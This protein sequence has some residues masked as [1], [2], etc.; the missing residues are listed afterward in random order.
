MKVVRR[1]LNCQS[2]FEANRF[3]PHDQEYCGRAECR[4]A[5]ACAA[6]KKWRT[7]QCEKDADFRRKEST[8]LRLYRQAQRRRAAALCGLDPRSMLS[9]L[10]ERLGELERS[11]LGLI[12][13][14]GGGRGRAQDAE[15]FLRRCR[16]LF[17][18]LETAE[19]V[20]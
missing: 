16:E 10:R 11:V 4:R 12:A 3:H 6:R 19:L 1:C 15:G 17:R 8:R 20:V 18:D 14:L 9:G 7:A 13:F 5:S 2:E